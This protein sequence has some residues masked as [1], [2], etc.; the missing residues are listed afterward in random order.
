MNFQPSADDPEVN[1][2]TNNVTA[3]SLGPRPTSF[4]NAATTPTDPFVPCERNENPVWIVSGTLYT[5]WSSSSIYIVSTHPPRPPLPALSTFC[6]DKSSTVM[7]F[8]GSTVFRP[9][10]FTARNSTFFGIH[11]VFR[12]CVSFFLFFG[13]HTSTGFGSLQDGKEGMLALHQGQS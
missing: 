7:G 4:P 5:Q 2:T 10:P 8:G 9:P 11:R 1:V 3:S 12:I 6:H 13:F